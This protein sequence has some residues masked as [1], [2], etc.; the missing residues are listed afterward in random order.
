MCVL[1]LQMHCVY[2]P[3]NQGA[4][5]IALSLIQD[6]N[7]PSQLH[8]KKVEEPGC[9]TDPR[10]FV[11]QLC[12]FKKS[13]FHV[14]FWRISTS[15]RIVRLKRCFFSIS[16]LKLVY[17]WIES[18][19]TSQYFFNS[20]SESLELLVKKKRSQRKIEI[21]HFYQQI[22]ITKDIKSGYNYDDD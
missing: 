13:W 16:I 3:D 10:T 15:R 17:P 20:R 21:R 19:T 22:P 9:N 1:C 11:L 12:E 8:H 2:W 4:Q 7:D 6:A 5:R 18:D 14:Q